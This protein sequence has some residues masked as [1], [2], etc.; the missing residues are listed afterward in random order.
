MPC[1][2]SKQRSRYLFLY[3]FLDH[4]KLIDII[5]DNTPENNQTIIIT[6]RNT[7]I[8]QN[9]PLTNPMVKSTVTKCTFKTQEYEQKVRMSTYT[10]VIDENTLR[11]YFPWVPEEH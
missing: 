4:N 10:K 11:I 7:P 8:F 9:M 3:K 1:Y 2:A 6:P 5:K